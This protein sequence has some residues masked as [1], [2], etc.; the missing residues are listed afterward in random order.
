VTSLAGALGEVR[1]WLAENQLDRLK[2]ADGL[3]WS[4]AV[5]PSQVPDPADPRRVLWQLKVALTVRATAAEFAATG[6]LHPVKD[7]RLL[8]LL[9]DD[10]IELAMKPLIYRAATET[11]AK[12]LI[13]EVL[14]KLK[15]SFMKNPL[16]EV[17]RQLIGRWVD[18]R[19]RFGGPGA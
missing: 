12:A 3:A 1:H 9:G 7:A 4:L 2:D 10:V 11:A 19:C 8:A 6:T 16:T 17:K 13:V 5:K 14:P 15:A 18:E